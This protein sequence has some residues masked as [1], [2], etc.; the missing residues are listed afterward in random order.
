MTVLEQRSI[1]ATHFAANTLREC[2]L[3]T[4]DYRPQ[5]GRIVGTAK[6]P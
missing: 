3:V 4:A 1:E 6:T 2:S 5:L